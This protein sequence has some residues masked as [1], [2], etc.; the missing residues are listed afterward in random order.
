T[1]AS[2]RPELSALSP[3]LEKAL[4]RDPEGRF[5][6]AAAMAEALYAV[7]DEAGGV[8]TPRE[9]GELVRSLRAEALALRRERIR[10]A[11]DEDESSVEVA[12]RDLTLS[13]RTISGVTSA[14]VASPLR[15]RALE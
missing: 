1:L 6:S 3:V 8:A 7:A 14:T 4:C 12:R 9:V 5:A 15:A 2:L 13:G 10:D 11:R